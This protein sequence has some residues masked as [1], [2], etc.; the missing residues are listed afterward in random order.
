M[1]KERTIFVK[2][3]CFHRKMGARQQS[4]E[5]N[6]INR[7]LVKQLISR[8]ICYK[9]FVET[10]LRTTRFRKMSMYKS[11]KHIFHISDFMYNGTIQRLWNAV[12]N[13]NNILNYPR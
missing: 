4:V 11:G 9:N 7:Y 1:E 12:L 13:K 5:I 3:D 2:L 8:N 6:E 10:N